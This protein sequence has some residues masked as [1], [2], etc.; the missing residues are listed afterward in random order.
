MCIAWGDT[1]GI[2]PCAAGRP[3][4]LVLSLGGGAPTTAVNKPACGPNESLQGFCHSLPGS[5]NHSKQCSQERVLVAPGVALL[6]ASPKSF[7]LCCPQGQASQGGKGGVCPSPPW[8]SDGQ[9]CS[10]SPCPT[11]GLQQCLVNNKENICL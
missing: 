10:D 8:S 3:G 7:S 1:A 6:R 5:S 11:V 2:V 9:P 4:P